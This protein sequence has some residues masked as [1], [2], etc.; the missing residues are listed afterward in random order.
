MDKIKKES[1]NTRQ[2]GTSNKVADKRKKAKAPGKRKSATGKTYYE[3]RKNRSDKPGSILGISN[4]FD[5]KTIN[6][7]DELKKEYHRLA[8]IYHPDAGGTNEQFKMLQ[9]EY[10]L[11]FKAL[12]NGSNLNNK[13]KETETKIDEN[14]RAAI[15]AVVGIPGIVIELVG[16][17]IWIGG[18][19]Y[20][21]RNEL[22]SAGFNF[23]PIK[24]MWFFKGVE[25]AGRGKMELDEIRKKYGSE[26]IT[27]NNSR[28]LLSGVE[29]KLSIAKRNKFKN[30]LKRLTKALNKRFV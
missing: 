19:T 15:D 30:S 2:T 9:A 7:L 29:H 20:P 22:K 13:Q 17:W 5:S 12:L 1:S 23:A 21:V 14:L 24:K 16:K 11:K 27:K 18:N 8:K 28:N 3:R 6:N 4:F 26:H 10:E 25:S